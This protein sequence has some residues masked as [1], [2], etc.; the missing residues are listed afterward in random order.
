MKFVDEVVIDVIAG[1]GGDGCLSFRREKYI[2][3]GG[4]N[5]G[6]GGHG[7]DVYLIAD[8]S[9]NTLVDFRFKRIYKATKGQHGMGSDCFGASGEDLYIK[10]PVGTLIYDHNT[11]VLLGDL[12]EKDQTLLVAKGGSRGLGNARFKTSTNRAPTKTTKG[13]PGEERKLKLEL[14]VLADV[15]LLG[16]PNAGKSTFISSVSSAKPKIADYP[17][18]TLHPN[19]GVVRV[20][21]DKSLVIADIPGLIEGA[22]EGIGLGIRFLK[23]LARTKILVHLVDVT[24]DTIIHDIKSILLELKKYSED[25]F[26]KE[27]ILVLN[28]IDVINQEQ[29]DKIKE[30]IINSELKD[31]GYNSLDKIY[32][33]SAVT[34]ENTK[35]LIFMLSERVF[36]K[37]ENEEG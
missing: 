26:T 10:I 15:G 7:G 35:E 4:P 37:E 21:F 19:L 2:E 34:H 12:K 29:L 8:S 14:Q 33:I 25:L 13:K 24:S 9:L 6:D 32:H 23:H 27:R 31:F 22:H 11:D 17:F 30:E 20:G 28:K 5:G 1:K 18:T 16:L 3:R 36:A